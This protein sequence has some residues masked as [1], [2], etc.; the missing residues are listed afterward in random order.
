MPAGGDRV[1]QM[2][3]QRLCSV[4]ITAPQGAGVRETHV[5]L[6]GGDW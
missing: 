6:L 1:I 3:K 4:T 2:P 5:G